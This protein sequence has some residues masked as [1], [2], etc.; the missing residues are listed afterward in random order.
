MLVE[1]GFGRYVQA[2]G[3]VQRLTDDL[4]GLESLFVMGG[5]RALEKAMPQLRVPGLGHL[6]RQT[7]TQQAPCWK[8]CEPLA[9]KAK[10]SGAQAILG[11]GGG[12]ALDIAKAAAEQSG[13]PLFLLPTVASTCSAATRFIALYD[14]QG[15]RTGSASLSRPIHGVYVDETLLA[16]APRRMLAAGIADSLAKLSETASAKLYRNNPSTPLWETAVSHAEH[17]ALQQFSFA[18][19]ALDGE[20][21]ALSRVLFANIYLTAQMTQLGSD[22]RIGELAHCFSNALTRLQGQE[23]VGE[24]TQL[25]GELVGLGVLMEMHLTG[26]IAGI[27]EK[28]VRIFLRDTLRCP[29]SL[30]DLDLSLDARALK[31]LAQDIAHHSGVAENW[32]ERGLQAIA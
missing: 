27:G 14:E 8:E 16:D 9:R 24:L 6:T 26:E 21:Q 28:Q 7:L 5:S 20:E 18:Q 15:R 23:G 17:I 1:A 2:P 10:E 32:I 19:A 25:H 11:V 13:L 22:R 12:A 29:V 30:R 3:A 31:A 4:R